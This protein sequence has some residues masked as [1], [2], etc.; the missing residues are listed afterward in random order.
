[1]RSPC[2]HAH[3][4]AGVLWSVSGQLVIFLF[5]YAGVGT[6]VTT[7]VFGKVLMRLYYTVSTAKIRIPNRNL[8][9]KPSSDTAFFSE[10]GSI[11]LASY[12]SLCILQG[13][14]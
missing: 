13:R 12:L 8:R 9:R 10:Y 7:S 5:L 2:T 1:M 14:Q 11:K 6:L 3:T 4:H